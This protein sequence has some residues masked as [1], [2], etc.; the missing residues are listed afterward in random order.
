MYFHA[1]SNQPMVYMEL[2]QSDDNAPYFYKNNFRSIII[3]AS[4]QP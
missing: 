2:N 4:S 3:L 1:Y